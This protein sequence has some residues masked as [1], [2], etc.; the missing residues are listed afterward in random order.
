[1]GSQRE[2]ALPAGTA[3]VAAA[4]QTTLRVFVMCATEGIT[5]AI[6]GWAVS[7]CGAPETK[8]FRNGGGVHR[9][10]KEPN[11]TNDW[12]ASS[13]RHDCGE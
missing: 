5:S 1:M 8:S 13:V 3:V 10:G 12:A 6:F 4:L 9:G 11:D 2:Y 7:G